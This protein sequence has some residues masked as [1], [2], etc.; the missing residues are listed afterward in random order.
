MRYFIK[1]YFLIIIFM[2]ISAIFT[3]SAFEF[4]TVSPESAA[5][6]GIRSILS[7]KSSSLFYNP[8]LLGEVRQIELEF[9]Y[10]KLFGLD[11]L[12]L[13]TAS[14]CAP[15]LKGGFGIGYSCFGESDFY[16]EEIINFGIGYNVFDDVFLGVSIKDMALYLGEIDSK[17]GIVGVD[18]GVRFKYR[19]S[20]FGFS[21][22]NIN[23]P[24]I[25]KSIKEELA[26]DFNFGWRL[27]AYK[28][29]DVLLECFKMLGF[30]PGYRLGIENRLF[31]TIFLRAGIQSRPFI[32]SCGLGIKS[33]IVLLSYAYTFHDNLGGQS[34]FCIGFAF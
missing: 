19:K 10:T 23:R 1:L 4:K 30:S 12:K 25:G 7:T 3:Y 2:L 26:R 15:F 27:E 16:K 32:Y 14:F 17:R 21:T 31:N 20:C 24:K 8:A 5:F 6:S 34:F 22:S 18:L 13:N 29:I 33:K 9:F 11:K 28:N